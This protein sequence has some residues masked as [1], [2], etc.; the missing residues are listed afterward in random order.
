M[1]TR[2]VRTAAPQDSIESAAQAMAELDVGALPVCDGKR[3]VGMVTDRDITVRCVAQGLPPAHT[4]VGDIV[5][6]DRRF[7]RD[8]QTVDEAAEMMQ[9]AGIRRLPVIDAGDNLVGI[10]T[11]GD[12]AVRGSEE[13]ASEALEGISQPA[14]PSRRA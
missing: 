2:G 6:R 13:L 8:S 7:C 3:L 10:L 4:P 1:M 5:S 14:L 9:A 11:V 12:I